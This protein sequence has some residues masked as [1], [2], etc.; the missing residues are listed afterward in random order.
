LF[1]LLNNVNFLI[2]P[3]KGPQRYVFLRVWQNFYQ[4][5]EFLPLLPGPLPFERLAGY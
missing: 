3:R 4:K 2:F 1:K 5:R